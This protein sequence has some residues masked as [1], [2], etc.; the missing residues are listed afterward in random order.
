MT[1]DERS[2]I[3]LLAEAHHLFASLDHYNPND[4]K[5]W[6]SHLHAMQNMV[7]S[8]TAVRRYADLFVE[9]T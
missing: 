7:L 6:L 8:R 3:K 1:Q 2:I 5:E 4:S 9:S